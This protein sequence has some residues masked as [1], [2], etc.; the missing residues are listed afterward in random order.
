VGGW[1]STLIEAKGREDRMGEVVKGK[2]EI[3]TTF[4]I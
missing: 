3:S 1:R 4:Q 2:P